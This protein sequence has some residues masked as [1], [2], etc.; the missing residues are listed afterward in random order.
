MAEGLSGVSTGTVSRLLWRADAKGLRNLPL[1]KY[2]FRWVGG[3][4][5]A[6]IFSSL[7]YKKISLYL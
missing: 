5:Q 4:G 6:E 3:V 1:R 2:F 7:I